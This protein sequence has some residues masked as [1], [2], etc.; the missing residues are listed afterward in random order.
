[1]CLSDKAAN[2]DLFIFDKL[3]NP[4][5]KTKDLNVWFKNIKKAIAGL[6]ESKKFLLVMS[7]GDDKLI[8]AAKNL[9]GV[10][11]ISA[12]SLNCVDLL[13]ADALLVGIKSVEEI[14]KVYK[15]VKEKTK[16]KS[17]VAV[18]KVKKTKTAKA[19][20]K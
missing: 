2:K 5:G 8:R 18:A 3:E 7:E 17:A 12:K 20:T 13:K 19:K 14:D 6:K 9:K 1:M 11:T 10:A 4:A 15:Q 16:E